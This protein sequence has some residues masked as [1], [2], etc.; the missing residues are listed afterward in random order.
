L[1]GLLRYKD[2]PVDEQRIAILGQ[3]INILSELD[4]PLTISTLIEI[5]DSEDPAL[6]N[7][8]GK[9]DSRHFRDIV[10][11]LQ[12]L[13]LL[14]GNLFLENADADVEQLNAERL[15][16]IGSGVGSKTRLSIINTSFLGDASIY[17]VA[18]FL[19]EISRFAARSPRN[20]LQA[21]IMFDEADQYLPAQ[22]KPATKAPLENLLRRAR[23]SGIGLMLATQSPGEMDYKSRDQV[24]NWFVGKIKEETAIKKLAPLF[25]ET[26]MNPS[27]KLAGQDTGEFFA[28]CGPDVVQMK[29]DL[30]LVRAETLASHEIL[31]VAAASRR[32]GQGVGAGD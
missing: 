19:L 27:D 15:L 17:W 8:I 4:K 14:R 12:A 1:G 7:A 32:A 18:Q 28:V 22:S 30:S 3:A 26:Q 24:L 31:E 25:A 16:G 6:I 20:Q 10:Q 5:I 11:R 9:L 23:A 29:A 2:N 13:K 21:V